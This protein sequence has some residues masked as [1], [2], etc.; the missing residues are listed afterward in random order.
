MSAPGIAKQLGRKQFGS[1]TF[2]LDPAAYHRSRPD[3]PEWVYQTLCSRWRR[4]SISLAARHDG[5]APKHLYVI[6]NNVSFF[7][8]LSDIKILKI[9]WRC[10]LN[11]LT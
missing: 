1:T 11:E 8:P 2:G 5:Y 9:F 6:S 4:A 7:C 10:P 3:F